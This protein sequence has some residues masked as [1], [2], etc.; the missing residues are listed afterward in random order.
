[1]RVGNVI[2]R[3]LL[4]RAR[5]RTTFLNRSFSMLGVVIFL[6]LMFGAFG[7][8]G[9][10]GG[11]QVLGRTVFFALAWIMAISMPIM[12]NL[13]TS[14]CVSRER[15][16]GT[17]GL[18]LLTNLRIRDVAFGKL[19][20]NSLEIVYIT[21]AVI[22]LA[23]VPLLSGGVPIAVILWTL[24]NIA[25]LLGIG[26]VSGLVASCTAT[27]AR[28]ANGIGMTLLAVT[29]LGPL[30]LAPVANAF[31]GIAPWMIRSVS[32]FTAMEGISNAA[33]S[34]GFLSFPPRM[35]WS[36]G[37]NAGLIV[38][39][40]LLATPIL[41][42]QWRIEV[43]GGAK[44]A[45]DASAKSTG[46]RRRREPI[47]E[48][49]PLS[50][51][52]RVGQSPGS[53]WVGIGIVFAIWFWGLIRNGE[54]QFEPDS[55]IFAVLMMNFVFKAGYMGDCVRVLFKE[56]RQGALELTLST[57]MKDYEVGEGFLRGLR[58]RNWRPFAVVNVFALGLIAASLGSPSMSGSDDLLMYV[59]FMAV[60]LGLGVFDAI[61][62]E[63]LGLWNGLSKNTYASAFGLTFG[64]VVILPL[65]VFSA[66]F[67][68]M[69]IVGADRFFAGSG[70]SAMYVFLLLWV[71][72]CLFVE[73]PFVADATSRLKRDLRSI[74]S[75]PMGS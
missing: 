39:L 54:N 43:G 18:L 29:Q 2:H 30:F 51:L 75:S 9:G 14:D 3:E 53:P 24:L 38:T 69:M 25:L 61:A 62:V 37:I 60:V 4:E 68:T 74:A 64:V 13:L 48:G 35:F 20:A 32:G 15:R 50:W 36:L 73:G 66:L 31:P 63:R 52:V 41:A 19:F 58:E 47:G 7:G 26:L 42:R 11:P 72:I 27:D 65:G 44:R 28:R 8:V 1:M 56:R 55:V 22:P 67:L 34:G 45:A 49:E 40:L 23:T 59:S 57:S 5:R 16:G 21:V 46:A 71:L 6:L 17:F 70:D 10:A 33:F 12:G